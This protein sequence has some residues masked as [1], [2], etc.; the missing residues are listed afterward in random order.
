ML[1]RAYVKKARIFLM[2]EPANNLDHQGDK[3]LMRKIQNLRGRATVL[4]VT[5]R[6]SH[7]RLADKV[8]YL[9]EGRLMLAGPPDQVLPQLGMG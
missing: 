7:M 6:P 5:H 8:L 2:D 3:D 1:A 4:L 9:E